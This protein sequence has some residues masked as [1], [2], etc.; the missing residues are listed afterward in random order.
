MHKIYAKT[1]WHVF[2]VQHRKVATSHLCYLTRNFINI[3]YYLTSHKQD[4]ILVN[5]ISQNHDF[6][7]FMIIFLPNKPH[8]RVQHWISDHKVFW[9]KSFPE[10][11]FFRPK[12]FF[13]EQ[14]PLPK[15]ISPKYGLIKK[16]LP[17]SKKANIALAHHHHRV[18]ARTLRPGLDTNSIVF[19][20]GLLAL[21]VPNHRVY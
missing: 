18:I 4:S 9:I 20:A 21:R 17:N 16:M 1:W 6:R 11:N 15:K 19:E 12:K 2:D 7:H 5:I 8:H 3:A 14:E 13:F 10:K